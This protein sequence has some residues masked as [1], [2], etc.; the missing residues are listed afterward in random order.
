MFSNQNNNNLQFDIILNNEAIV[1]ET[2]IWTLARHAHILQNF[3]Q[4][5][6]I[7]ISA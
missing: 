5:Q 1:L 2:I 4:F 7:I 6:K 3:W